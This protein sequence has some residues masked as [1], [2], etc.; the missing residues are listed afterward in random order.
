M[1]EQSVSMDTSADVDMEQ[2]PLL[3][4]FRTPRR[5]GTASSSSG[6]AAQ[7]AEQPVRQTLYSIT[8]V[9]RWLKNNEGALSSSAQ[10]MRIREVVDVLNKKPRPRFQEIESFLKP[11]NVQQKIKQQRKPLLELIEALTEK[12]VD[13]AKELQ[14]QLSHSAEQP[15]ASMIEQSV[16]VDTSADV[17]LDQNPLLA[18]FRT[19][20]RKGAQSGSATASSSSGS[21]AHS[22][23]IT[24]FVGSSAERHATNS[25]L[26]G[27]SA[28]KL[29]LQS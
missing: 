22:A 21:A 10:G 15:G 5:S 18:E 25:S 4:E 14:Q 19:R 6:S 13:A 1:T 27:S 24:S 20:Q 12:A 2:N 11:W 8:D 16:F 3:A 17:D 7:P 9:Q 23:R 26:A 29:K 28:V